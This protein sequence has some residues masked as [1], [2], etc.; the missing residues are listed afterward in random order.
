MSLFPQKDLE[1]R[2]CQSLALT[3]EL[4][5]IIRQLPRVTTTCITMRKSQ[6]RFNKMEKTIRQPSPNHPPLGATQGSADSSSWETCIFGPELENKLKMP[7]ERHRD[8]C[9]LPLHTPNPQRASSIRAWL[10]GALLT[11]RNAPAF[12]CI[13]G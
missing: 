11:L 7:L 9:Y 1:G 12:I 5:E 8:L 2:Q 10:L 13:Q 4:V 3:S 6:Q